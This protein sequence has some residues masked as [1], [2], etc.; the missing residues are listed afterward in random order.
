M[1]NKFTSWY[2]EQ[3]RQQLDNELNLEDINIKI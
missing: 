3:V 1:K 2:S